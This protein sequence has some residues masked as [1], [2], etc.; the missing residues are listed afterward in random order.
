MCWCTTLVCDSRWD[1]KMSTRLNLKIKIE[2]GYNFTNKIAISMARLNNTSMMV[3]TMGVY[4]CVRVCVCVSTHVCITWARQKRWTLASPPT[5]RRHLTLCV[6]LCVHVCICACVWVSMSECMCVF[7]YVYMRVYEWVY[8]C[9]CLC[10]CVS[11]YVC[12]CVSPVSGSTLPA[13]ESTHKAELPT[14]LD[15]RR[16]TPSRC[17]CMSTATEDR[18]VSAV[19]CI[20]WEIH[21]SLLYQ[22]LG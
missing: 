15:R 11:V 3:F 18:T 7:M 16:I 5:T 4:V 14:L 20:W 6:C 1:L 12:V 9:V 19:S 13:G 17:F 21:V 2:R 8:V 22:N 10:M